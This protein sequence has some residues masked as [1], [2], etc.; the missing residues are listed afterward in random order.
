MSRSQIGY[1][2]S[3]EQFPP[4]ALLEYAELAEA[5]GISHVLASDHFHPW[6]EHQGES[7]FVWTWLG[8]VAARTDLTLGTVTAPGYRYHPTIVAQAAATLRELHPGKAWL[9]IGSG[10]L[11]NEGV[12]GTDWPVKSER[13]ARL[14]ECA[15]VIRSLWNGETVTHHGRVTVEQATVYTRPETE[16]PLVGAA[17][18][19][20]TAR[21]LGEWADG[22]ITVATPDREGL[23]RRI[24]AFRERAPEK[25][26]YLKA[27]HAYGPDE[28]SARAGAIEQWRSQCIP[29]VVT[30][31]L[32]TPDDYDA[33]AEMVDPE[34]VSEHVRIAADPETHLEWLAGDVAH[35]VDRI[36]VHDVTTG[37]RQFIE[38][39]LGPAADTV[40]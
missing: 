33:L 1:H 28:E 34:T 35:D 2:A 22:M 27:Q 8:A 20:E 5:S 9:A 25:P 7:G 24:D 18:S 37:Q 39:V 31:E 40:G 32:R 21:W 26:V 4:S 16:P 17:L 38:E 6:S 14:R 3:H 15:D 23:Q 30:Q 36:Y 10:Q 19:E 29:G 12:T 11:L 13:N